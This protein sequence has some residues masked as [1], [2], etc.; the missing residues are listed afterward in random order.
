MRSLFDLPFKVGFT[1]TQLGMSKKQ[2]KELKK[3]LEEH[4]IQ[5]FHH[6]DCVGADEQAHNLAKE[7]GIK[8]VIHPPT[9][10]DKRAF[11]EG[12]TI[13]PKHDYLERNKH[14]VDATNLLLAAP[15]EMEEL[16]RSGTWATIRYAKKTG[17][18][19][20]IFYPG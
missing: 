13:L 9:V 14:I 6:G 12:G 15:K 3:W 1:G 16:L 8:V 11:C 4:K 17:K 10:P 18:E 5:E 19:V 20:T 7:L 2:K